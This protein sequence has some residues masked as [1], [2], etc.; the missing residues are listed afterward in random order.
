MATNPSTIPT[1]VSPDLKMRTF[2]QVANREAGLRQQAA[3][4]ARLLGAGGAIVGHLIEELEQL[5][6]DALQGAPPS[7]SLIAPTVSRARE[8]LLTKDKLFEQ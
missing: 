6:R 3:D 7:S 2:D 8:W 1:A 4:M 5:Q